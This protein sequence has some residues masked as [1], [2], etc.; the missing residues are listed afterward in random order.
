MWK[1][2]Q[3]GYPNPDHLA[4][5]FK[6]NT[7]L[8]IPEQTSQHSN[9]TQSGG[10][11]TKQPSQQPNPAAKAA[12]QNAVAGAAVSL[13]GVG[14]LIYWLV[15]FSPFGG[16]SKGST[17]D[18]AIDTWS[19]SGNHITGVA[20]NTGGKSFGY[21]Q[22][23]FNVYDSTGAQIGSTLANVNNLQPGGTWKFEAYVFEANAASARIAGITAW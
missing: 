21:V 12:A 1:C 14:F 18:I 20:R 2:P 6:C 15:A 13:I 11:G 10:T 19:L 8:A 7:R 16:S 22:I 4:V 23:E 3:C 17:Q 9:L 5:C